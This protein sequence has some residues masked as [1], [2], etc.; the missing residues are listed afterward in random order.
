VSLKSMIC[1]SHALICFVVP[2]MK[3][4]RKRDREVALT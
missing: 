2:K 4:T 3:L 1:I